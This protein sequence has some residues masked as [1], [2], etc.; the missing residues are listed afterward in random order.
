MKI[1]KKSI[2]MVLKLNDEQL[3]KTIQHIAKKSGNEKFASM[4]KPQDMSKIRALL[5][6]LTD[7]E[8][9]KAVELF[10]QGKGK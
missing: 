5:S 7:E 1:D 8:I 6:S 4:E 9:E 2:D 10:K 3:W